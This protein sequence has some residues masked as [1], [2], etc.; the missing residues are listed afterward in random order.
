M[1][2]TCKVSATIQ[3]DIQEPETPEESMEH[4]HED[5]E[6]QQVINGQV[7]M[8]VYHFD[9]ISN[10]QSFLCLALLVYVFLYYFL[11]YNHCPLL[12]QI[13]WKRTST[14]K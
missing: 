11:L 12:M 10:N 1:A 9:G 5:Q 7:C 3:S 4:F 2:D 6:L 8:K 14:G 13:L